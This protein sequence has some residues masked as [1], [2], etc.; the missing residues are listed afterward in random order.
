MFKG[1]TRV[2]GNLATFSCRVNCASLFRAEILVFLRIWDSCWGV[3]GAEN[4]VLG[5]ELVISLLTGDMFASDSWPFER[6]S[7]AP[8]LTH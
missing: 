3:L 5:V 4:S 8:M 7:K 2:V 1:C 6:L